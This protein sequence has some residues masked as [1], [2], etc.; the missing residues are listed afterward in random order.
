MDF[1]P[2][3]L[4]F[5]DRKKHLAKMKAAQKFQRLCDLHYD[6]IPM[7]LAFSDDEMDPNIDIF[8]PHNVSDDEDRKD[9][10]VTST[11]STPAHAPRGLR[12]SRRV[13][14]RISDRVSARVS[15]FCLEQA[16]IDEIP[17]R[18]GKRIKVSFTSSSEDYCI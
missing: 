18:S 9:M 2:K 11:R 13:S 17:I 3:F 14:G 1:P 10:E 6:A 12:R 7:G 15:A 4:N 16:E 8:Q 5:S